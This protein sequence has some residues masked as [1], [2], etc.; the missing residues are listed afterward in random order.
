MKQNHSEN[1][2]VTSTTSNYYFIIFNL[3]VVYEIRSIDIL[4]VVVL[5][6]WLTK[7]IALHYLI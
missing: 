3:A 5:E 4:L 7:A 6:S 1:N 2:S